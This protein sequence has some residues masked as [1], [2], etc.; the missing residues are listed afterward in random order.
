M[1]EWRNFIST[2]DP[3]LLRHISNYI[4]ESGWWPRILNAERPY[5]KY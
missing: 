2:A 5:M 3:Y 4:P 1:G